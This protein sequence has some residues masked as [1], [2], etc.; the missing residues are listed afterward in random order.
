MAAAVARLCIARLFLQHSRFLGDSAWQ[1]QT[2]REEKVN[3]RGCTQWRRRE[4]GGGRTEGPWASRAPSV[5]PG[6]CSEGTRAGGR[7]PPRLVHWVLALKELHALTRAPSRAPCCASPTEPRLSP[8]RGAGPPQPPAPPLPAADRP[9]PH[10]TEKAPVS[11]ARPGHRPRRRVLRRR[12]RALTPSCGSHRGTSS[13]A[14]LSS[15]AK[16]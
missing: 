2:Q 4:T 7:R 9:D 3:Q 15:P 13:S 11:P 5:A 12:C 10:T 14:R 16:A 8:R 6:I 1:K